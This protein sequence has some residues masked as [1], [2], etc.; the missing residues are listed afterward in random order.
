[1]HQYSCSYMYMY[2]PINTNS[3]TLIRKK[4]QK[5]K[6]METENKHEYLSIPPKSNIFAA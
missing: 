6:F 3:Y 5:S 4:T 2:L 1:M